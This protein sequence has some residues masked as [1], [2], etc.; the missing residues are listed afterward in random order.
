MNEAEQKEK[1]RADAR[2]RKRRERERKKAHKKACGA[3]S[4]S[5]ELYRG[6]RKCLD[7]LMEAGGFDERSELLTLLLHGVHREMKHDKS[8]FLDLV[9]IEKVNAGSSVKRDKSRFEDSKECDGSQ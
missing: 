9:S 1:Q 4:I 3:H 8:K 6:T 5:F 7:E 2:E